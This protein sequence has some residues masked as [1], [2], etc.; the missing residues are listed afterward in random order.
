MCEN[1]QSARYN[2]TYLAHRLFYLSLISH[3]CMEKYN[4]M[5]CM[6][7]KNKGSTNKRHF[8][9][10]EK[11]DSILTTRNNQYFFITQEVI[12]EISI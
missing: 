1:N 9:R 6:H 11:R 5:N 12:F 8:L 2:L 7:V 4:I 10:T 3:V